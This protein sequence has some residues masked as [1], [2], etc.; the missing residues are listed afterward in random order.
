M[1]SKKKTKHMMAKF[2]FTKDRV[3]IREIKVI[4]CLTGE[5][6]VDIMTKPLQGTAFKAMQAKLMNHPLN[7]EDSVELPEV[8]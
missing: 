1:S 7:Y 5:M 4:T 2:F 8:K 6:W 3:D